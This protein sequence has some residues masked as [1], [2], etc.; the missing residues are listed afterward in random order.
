MH[1]TLARLKSRLARVTDLSY[2]ASVLSWDQE[3]MMPAGGAAARA[4][5]IAT[6]Q[7]LAHR[8]FT[9]DEV[10]ALLAE[11]APWAASLPQ[12]S[13][14][15]SIVRVRRR[16]YDRLVRVPTE[17]VEALAR[18]V[19]LAKQA[20]REARER[21]DF[22]HFRPHLEEILAL[23]IRWAG[24]F[25]PFENPYDPLL[26]AFEP[27]MTYDGIRNVF[28][29]LKP[30][31]VDLVAKIAVNQAAVDD[32]LLRRP[33]DEARQ[34]ALSRDVTAR[35][36]YDY[37][38]G[39]LDLSAHPFS[40]RFSPGDVRITTRVAEADPITSLM[41]SIH[42]AGHA[43]HAQALSPSL[44]RTGLDVG[45]M[46]AVAESQ[47]RF[48]ENVIG[49]SL[50]FWRWLQP[51]LRRAYAPAFD[52]ATAEQLYRAVNKV[53]PGLIRVDADEVTYG[54]HIMLRFELENELING[55]LD[56]G[57]LPQAWNDRMEAYLG[58]R[59]PH[60]GVGV[61]QD[62]HWSSGYIGY[63]PDYLLGSLFSVQ[64]WERMRAELPTVEAEI[65]SGGFGAPLA[66]LQ[67]RVMRHGRKF[68]LA[69][70]SERA[71]GSPLRWE[72]YMA[73]LEERYGALYGV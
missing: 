25:A 27:G 16:D 13:D 68:T 36:G 48:Y 55:R 15:A 49:R 67:E 19:S 31:L 34:I 60:D 46:Q 1:E 38:R 43:I 54:L 40:S 71:V 22:A 45:N 41:S 39:R 56:A 73:Y 9:D 11:L 7:S 42:E 18:A 62:I 24:C 72:P 70:L 29:G 59:P 32:A 17:L 64:L 47:S 66:W 37:G 69:E 61:L 8:Y 3:T 6:L 30:R 14:E 20:W 5:Q 10:G 52:H 33:V 50:L 63:F 23:R 4:D 12:G 65:E 21:R 35:L 28:D 26:D 2:A 57:E 53:E 44:Y 51:L 58:V